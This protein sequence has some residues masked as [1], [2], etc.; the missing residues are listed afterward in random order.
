MTG[1]KDGLITRSA[2]GKSAK[3]EQGDG[4]I[5]PTLQ[6]TTALAVEECW[7]RYAGCRWPKGEDDPAN[8]KA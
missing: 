3:G 2:I 8:L 7:K 6:E 4:D 5:P 1:P